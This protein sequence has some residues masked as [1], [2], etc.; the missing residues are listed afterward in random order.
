MF[1]DIIIPT[2]NPGPEIFDAIESCLE[3]SYKSINVIIV[4]DFSSNDVKSMIKPYS[5]VSYLRTKANL[6][7]AGARN[8]GI[9][10]TRSPLISFLDSDDIMCKDKIKISAKALGKGSSEGMSC[11]NY[12]IYHNR[13]KL[14]PPFYGRPIK[15]DHTALMRR[16]WVASG[17]VTVK[18]SVL[19]EV[20]VFD[21]SLRVCEDYDLWLRISEKYKIKY[22][23]DVLYYYSVVPSGSSLTQG[24]KSAVEMA[25]NEKMIRSRSKARVEAGGP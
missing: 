14:R 25:G 1:V 9:K 2:Y 16:N 12:R 17:S 24:S 13:Q 3:Q 6:G 5:E 15:I 10:N 19:D 7:P 21:E 8:Y 18:R 11:G 20:G 4:D 22:I 23:H